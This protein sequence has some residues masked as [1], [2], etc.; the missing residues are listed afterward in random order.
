MCRT[1][2]PTPRQSSRSWSMGSKPPASIS[3][4]A[5]GYSGHRAAPRRRAYRRSRQSRPGLAPDWVIWKLTQYRAPVRALALADRQSGDRRRLDAAPRLYM[6]ACQR[7]TLEPLNFGLHLPA[8]PPGTYRVTYWDTTTG[9]VIGEENITLDEGSDGMC[10]ASNC[11]RSRHQ[12]AVRRLPYRRARGRTARPATQYCH[13][14]A[15]DQ[16]LTP[17]ETGSPVPTATQTPVPPPT[18]TRH[19]SHT[20]PHRPLRQHCAT[21]TATDTLTPTEYAHANTQRAHR[22]IRPP[23]PPRPRYR[24]IDADAPSHPSMTPALQCYTHRHGAPPPLPR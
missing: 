9:S 5:A 19:H 20:D 11:C 17:T 1:S 21:S 10:C 24:Y 15:A 6:A 13:A 3:A 2:Q 4:P 16:C 18:V 14:H 22:P 8:M 7:N 23:R 12:L